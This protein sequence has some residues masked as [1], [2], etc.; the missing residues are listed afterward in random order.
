MEQADRSAAT[1]CDNCDLVPT[2]KR[3]QVFG[4]VWGCFVCWLLA[5]S[6]MV[7]PPTGCDSDG[8]SWARRDNSQLHSG[9]PKAAAAPAQSATCS[10]RSNHS[11]GC[12]RG[13]HGVI[14]GWDSRNTPRIAPTPAIVGHFAVHSLGLLALPRSAGSA[15]GRSPSQRPPVVG[16][17]EAGALP[18]DGTV[19]AGPC[20]HHACASQHSASRSAGTRC[21][22]Q[23]PLLSSRAP[24]LI[25]SSPLL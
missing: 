1:V 6:Q 12:E 25:T 15:P 17:Q 3:A 21:L 22:L 23:Q 4:L 9:M 5:E 24:T 7:T 14:G 18:L 2:N 16:G 8:G 20:R 11:R 13:W 19:D 10:T